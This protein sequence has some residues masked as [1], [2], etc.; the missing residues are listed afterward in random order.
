MG[1]LWR[2]EPMALLQLFVPHEAAQATVEALGDAGVAQFVDVRRCAR[3]R[4]ASAAHRSGR[5]LNDDVSA[6]R[7]HFAGELKRL[8]ALERQLAFLA[9]E[10]QRSAPRFAFQPHPEAVH[11]Y[12]GSVRMLCVSV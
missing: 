1:S 5:Q 9:R 8:R 6:F 7:Q 3:R 10:L 11:R 2:S 4:R 12:T